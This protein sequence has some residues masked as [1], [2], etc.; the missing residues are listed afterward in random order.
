MPPFPL[1]PIVPLPS[2]WHVRVLPPVSVAGL[3]PQDARKEKLVRDLSRYVQD[4][5]QQN[6]HHMLARRKHV[7]WGRVLDGTSPAVSPFQPAS[8]AAGA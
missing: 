7:F 2:K 3:A 6:I 8:Y 4:L 1:L 5:V